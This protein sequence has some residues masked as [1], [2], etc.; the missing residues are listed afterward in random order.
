M[1]E[2]YCSDCDSVLTLEDKSMSTYD[3][4]EESNYCKS[5]IASFQDDLE[6]DF[7]NEIL[8]DIQGRNII[9]INDD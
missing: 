2:E 6:V 3:A 9:S 4:K 8:E 7:H 1:D 5:C